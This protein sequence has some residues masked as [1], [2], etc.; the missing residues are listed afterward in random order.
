MHL[1]DGGPRTFRGYSDR[2]GPTFKFLNRSA[3]PSV[4]KARDTLELWFARIPDAKKTDVRRR[5]RGSNAEHKGAFLEI[6]TDAIFR[7]T[8]CSVDSA[9]DFDGLTPDLTAVRDGIPIVVECTVVQESDDVLRAKQRENVVKDVLDSI[10]TGRFYLDCKLLESPGTSPPTRRLKRELEGWLASL[11]P[12]EEM[13]RFNK[14]SDLRSFVWDKDGWKVQFRAIPASPQKLER[15][16]ARAIGMETGEAVWLQDG[17]K[18]GRALE[19]KAERYKSMVDSPYLI[20]ASLDTWSASSDDVHDALFGGEIY[21]FDPSSPESEHPN[22][23]SRSFDG[24]F[25]SPSIPR[26]RHV[27]A[28]LY[29]PQLGLW[30]FCDSDAPWQLVHNPWAKRPLAVGLFPFVTEWFPDRGKL[31]E[32]EPT[33]TLNKVLDLPN[34]WPGWER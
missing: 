7:A 33:C 16:E 8:G 1:F 26:N 24:L 6:A 14:L 20:V 34:P 32:R 11:D 9:A 22:Q 10:D 2:A 5:F 13:T 3:W 15:K 29:K 17:V 4:E 30:N 28:I 23:F 18:L 25:G 27:S 12:D 19:K 21:T 31:S